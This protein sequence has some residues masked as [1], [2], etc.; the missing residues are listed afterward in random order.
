MNLP[1]Y[2]E[3]DLPWTSDSGQEK[4]FQ[5]LLGSIFLVTLAL[6]L[7]WPFIPVPEPDPFLECWQIGY[8]QRSRGPLPLL[9]FTPW[10]LSVRLPQYASP[11][12]APEGVAVTE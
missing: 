7:V 10:E 2:R 11:V 5:R 4:K 1:F 12:W 9:L 6:G 8:Q 3:F